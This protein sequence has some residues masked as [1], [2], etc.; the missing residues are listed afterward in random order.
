MNLTQRRRDAEG[1][2]MD[3]GWKRESDEVGRVGRGR[4]GRTRQRPA[5]RQGPA[6]RWTWWTEWTRW[7]DTLRAGDAAWG[8]ALGIP[9]ELGELAGGL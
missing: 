5:S 9:V 7:T 3:R 6:G 1:G 4:T 2:G 8:A